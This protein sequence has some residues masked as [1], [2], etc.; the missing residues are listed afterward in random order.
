MYWIL[1]FPTALG[2]IYDDVIRKMIAAGK[3][4]SE[5]ILKVSLMVHGNT[6]FL[7]SS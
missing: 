5:N 7:D 6:K 1:D 3:I 4:E 2:S